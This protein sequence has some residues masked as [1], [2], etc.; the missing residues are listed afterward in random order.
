MTMAQQNMK[1]AASVATELN[2]ALNRTITE[3][4]RSLS[5]LV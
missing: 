4:A 2:A 1:S 3:G 5:K